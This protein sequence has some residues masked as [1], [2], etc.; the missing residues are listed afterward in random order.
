MNDAVFLCLTNSLEGKG[1]LSEVIIAFFEQVRY[2]VV[3]HLV[4]NL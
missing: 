1:F 2:N 4:T 3:I